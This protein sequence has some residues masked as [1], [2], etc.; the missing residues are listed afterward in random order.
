MGRRKKE[1]VQPSRSFV[2]TDRKPLKKG[3]ERGGEGK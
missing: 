2:A 3:E 1:R